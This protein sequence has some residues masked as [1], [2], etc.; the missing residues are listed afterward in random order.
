MNKIYNQS[1]KEIIACGNVGSPIRCK[2]QFNITFPRCFD[3]LINNWIRGGLERHTEP[4]EL[5]DEMKKYPVVNEEDRIDLYRSLYFYFTE[6]IKE[7]GKNAE[8]WD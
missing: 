5:F 7:A 6:W 3:I 4:N 2:E 8:S 1:G